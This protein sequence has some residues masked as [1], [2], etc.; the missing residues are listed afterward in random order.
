MKTKNLFGILVLFLSVLSLTSCNKNE[1]GFS[2]EE[3]QQ[4]L[5]DMKGTYHGSVQVAYYQGSNITELQNAVAVSR[6]SLKF[7][8]SLQPLSDL[9]SDET[10]AERL[11]EIGEVPIMAGYEFL[12]WDSGC[13]HFVLYPKDVT[14][15]GGYG[16]PPSIRLVF[17]MNYGGDAV[18]YM[19]SMNF[20][21]SPLELWV[22]GKKYDD[23]PRLVY[24]FE[25]EYE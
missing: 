3:V 11:R 24:H 13:I 25:G 17:S 23:F 18:T 4:A 22:D 12:Q 6:D 8:M 9:I 5:F 20:N 1:K 2:K 7:N 15:L 19:N 10:I 14:I 21:M 16:A